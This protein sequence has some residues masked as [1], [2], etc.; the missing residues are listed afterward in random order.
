MDP[1][2]ATGELFVLSQQQ[3]TFFFEQRSC[4]F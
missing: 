1:A 4:S 2:L 3:I